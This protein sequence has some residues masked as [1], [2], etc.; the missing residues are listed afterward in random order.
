MR[1]MIACKQ[2]EAS[3][4][5]CKIING[6]KN[7]QT[8]VSSSSSEVRRKLQYISY[9]III[10][11]T[12]LSDEFGLDLV[13]DFSDTLDSAFVV[14]VKND[15]ADQVEYKLRDT[16]AFVVPKP[17]NPRALQQNIRFVS[18]AGQ[19]LE[20]LRARNEQLIKKIE[21]MKII[22]RAKCCLVA[23]LSMTEEE[24]HRHIQKRS[25]DLRITPKEVAES[26]LKEYF[27]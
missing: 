17:V 15:I 26:I 19:K 13:F 6:I 16:S 9:D 21:D 12:P 8:D 1:I 4:S 24:A 7:A 27:N 14:L 10:V 25:M 22:D 20:K 23:S 2:G 3:D 11:N 5:L 18:K